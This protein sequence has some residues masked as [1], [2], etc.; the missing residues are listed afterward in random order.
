MENWWFWYVVGR[1]LPG[2]DLYTHTSCAGIKRY[3]KY[4]LVSIIKLNCEHNIILLD[5]I[6]LFYFTDIYCF[7]LTGDKCAYK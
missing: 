5:S 2:L 3:F 1:C 6:L 7:F 4:R